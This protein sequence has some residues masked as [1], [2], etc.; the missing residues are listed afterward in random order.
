MSVREKKVST[1]N[2]VHPDGVKAKIDFIWG[3][4]VD[5]VPKGLRITIK[6]AGKKIHILQDEAVYSSF[7][8]AKKQGIK[9]AARV[10]D[11][12]GEPLG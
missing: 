11:L 8:E 3:A 12:L 1:I 9:L 2:Y 5:P 6:F 7:E 10:F 4:K